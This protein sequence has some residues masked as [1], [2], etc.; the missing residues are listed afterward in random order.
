MY[1][2]ASARFVETMKSGYYRPMVIAKVMSVNGTCTNIPVVSGTVTADRTSQDFRRSCEFVVNSLNGYTTTGELINLIPR[3][4]YDPLNIYGNHIYL[5]RG[6]VWEPSKVGNDLDKA[7]APIPDEILRPTSG[8]YELVPIG[9]FRLN[10]VKLTEDTDGN[11]T[12]T[13]DGTDVSNN[14]SKNHWT[15]PVTV[16][17]SAY[18]VPV[19]PSD[20]GP[21]SV[22]YVTGA[23]Y[24]GL[25]TKAGGVLEAIKILINDRWPVNPALWPLSDKNFDFSGVQDQKI[26]TPIVMGSRTVSN[27]GSNSPWTDI[28]NLAVS[29]GGGTGELFV[30]V[31]GNFKIVAVT[32]PNA[33][34]PVWDYLDG[35]SAQLGGRLTSV[36][37][38]ITDSK[39]VNYVIATGESVTL[40]SPHKAIAVDSDPTSPTYYRG[41]FGR[42]VGYEPG[43]KL[44]TTQQQVQNAADTFLNW[45][46]GGDDQ[47]IIKGVVNP[48]LDVNDVVRVRR[49][50]LGIYDDSA[51]V[52]DVAVKMSSTKPYTT[53]KVHPLLAPIQAGTVLQFETSVLNQP[54][55][56][57]HTALPKET[58][59]SVESFTPK[60][61]YLAGTTITDP[62]RVSNNGAVNYYVDKIVIPLD[63]TT[64]MEMTARERRIGTRKD[65]I[66]IGEYSQAD[67]NAGL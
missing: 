66:R 45:F 65:A 16:W 31:E 33:V 24:G 28:S 13:V 46:V 21:K 19:T 37:R 23:N 58:S 54:I 52:A 8:A 6:V 36:N 53:I 32:D 55:V 4:A 60:Q 11:A 57:T 47:L 41:P 7:S 17:H 3:K 2:K 43:R 5:Y 50:R 48:L 25:T 38:V 35:D 64:D 29:I 51:V 56:V 59:I 42:V 63:L 20:I 26:T 49:K 9:V 15:D 18:S 12:I 44:L 1:T 40:A 10:T 67:P 39:T 22:D 61:D 62:T 27:S 30:D 34:A 14:I